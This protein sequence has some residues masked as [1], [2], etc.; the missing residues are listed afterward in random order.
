MYEPK[1]PTLVATAA[2]A[3]WVAVLSL[4]MLTGQW[5]G[6]PFGD[7]NPA[8]FASRTWGAAWWHRLG[9]V[10]LWEPLLF[11]GMPYI[12]AGHGDI[13]YPTSFLRLVFPIAAVFDFGFVLHYIL[14]GLFTYA[15]LR[16]L[17]VSW[18][19]SVMAALAYELT[20]LMA[21]YPSPGHD[22]KLF[23]CAALPLALL[24]LVMALRD[25]QW[26]GY[27]ILALAV[28]SPATDTRFSTRADAKSAT[29]PA[30][31]SRPS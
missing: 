17:N 9:H 5:L 21:S 23:A 11:G 1:R 12:G 16:R 6:S 7:F 24:A 15:L 4:P 25:K 30:A 31:R 18:G 8:G 26:E 10:P 3:L 19:G 14:A 13:F 27:G 22:G 28:A 2:C 20:G 29:S